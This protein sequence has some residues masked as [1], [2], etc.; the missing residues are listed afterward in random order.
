MPLCSCSVIPVVASMRRHGASRAAATAFLLSSP[1]TGVDSIAVTYA[2]LGPL[3]AVFRPVAALLSGV[4]GGVLVSVSGRTAAA[5][6]R[7]AAPPKC[8]DDMLHRRPFA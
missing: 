4:L 8:T 2:L 1:Q 3:F 7:T 5:K 6:R